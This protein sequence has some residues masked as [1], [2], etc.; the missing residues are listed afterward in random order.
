[1]ANKQRNKKIEVMLLQRDECQLH[2]RGVVALATLTNTPAQYCT[3]LT[4]GP[5]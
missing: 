4:E 5:W 3:V 2:A 1:M